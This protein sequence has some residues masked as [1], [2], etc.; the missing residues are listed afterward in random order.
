MTQARIPRDFPVVVL[1]HLSATAA[2]VSERRDALAVLSLVT[3]SLA[4][5]SYVST[6]PPDALAVQLSMNPGEIARSIRLL[7]GVHAINLVRR[8]S[9]LLIAVT[10][11]AAGALATGR[12]D[13]VVRHRLADAVEEVFN[14]ACASSNLDEAADLLAVLEKWARKRT[15]RRGP[16]GSSIKAMQ[17]ELERLTALR[18]GGDLRSGNEVDEFEPVTTF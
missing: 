9:R 8:H 10:P 15:G 11:A 6:Q 3:S 13:L 2:T 4:P 12:P 14:R 16:N 7:V 1:E 5:R 18:A 17:A